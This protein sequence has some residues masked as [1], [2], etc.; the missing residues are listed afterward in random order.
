MN[1]AEKK[2][3]KKGKKAHSLQCFESCLAL[4]KYLW[5]KNEKIST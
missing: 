5:K 1:S 2:K 4:S 3:R